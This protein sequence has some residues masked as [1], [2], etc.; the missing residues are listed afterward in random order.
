MFYVWAPLSVS[1]KFILWFIARCLYPSSFKYLYEFQQSDITGI[2]GLLCS[3]MTVTKVVKL[4]SETNIINISLFMRWILPKIHCP[5]TR[6]YLL[7]F[8][9]HFYFNNSTLPVYVE[10]FSTHKVHISRQKLAQPT[11]IREEVL[12]EVVPVLYGT[13]WSGKQFIHK[14]VYCETLFL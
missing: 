8:S 12:T 7:N 13:Q 5:V 9:P 1:T 6:R 3:L 2:S 14:D 10:C 4:R 11:A